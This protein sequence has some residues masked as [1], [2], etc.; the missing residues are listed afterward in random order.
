MYKNG[1]T[2]DP[3]PRG[4]NKLFLQK[5]N[6]IHDQNTYPHILRG[7]AWRFPLWVVRAEYPPF[8]P[9]SGVELIHLVG[10]CG[11]SRCG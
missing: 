7:D 11:V 8:R 4:L 9:D 2:S 6:H 5:R 10:V 1:K 3:L